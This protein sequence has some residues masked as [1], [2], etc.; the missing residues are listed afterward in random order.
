MK[1]A[2]TLCQLLKLCQKYS[3]AYCDRGAVKTR[4]AE[5]ASNP[6]TGTD[7]CW[8][9]AAARRAANGGAGPGES[10]GWSRPR[11]ARSLPTTAGSHTVAMSR[12][13][14]PQRGHASPSIPKA[15]GIRVAQAQE[16]GQREAPRAARRA[17]P[18]SLA[19]DL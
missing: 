5:A 13:R 19:A 1:T 3:H 12:S 8:E 2:F 14:P 7:D 16:R 9:G 6:E 17:A 10:V 18:S 11:G 15:R 4:P